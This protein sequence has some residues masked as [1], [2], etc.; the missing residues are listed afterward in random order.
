MTNRALCLKKIQIIDF[1]LNDTALYLDTHPNCKEALEYYNKYLEMRKSAVKEYV[2]LFGPLEQT[3]A[4]MC[5]GAWKW[6]EG[7]WPW[8]KRCCE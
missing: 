1:V 3:D 2:N 5:G 4:D 7:P 6:A 8:E